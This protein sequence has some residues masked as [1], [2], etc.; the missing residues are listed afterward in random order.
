M[1]TLVENLEYLERQSWLKDEYRDLDQEEMLWDRVKKAVRALE[2]AADRVKPATVAQAAEH[3]IPP[4][5]AKTL[6]M[7]QHAA[8]H[9]RLCLL[10]CT[11]RKTRAPITVLCGVNVDQASSN[12]YE[13]VP[14]AM[15]FDGNPYEILNPPEVS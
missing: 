2:V 8:Q 15:L 7:I 11:D 10:S 14:F 3:R 12:S 9:G 4:G 13:F 1:A 5:H 6:D